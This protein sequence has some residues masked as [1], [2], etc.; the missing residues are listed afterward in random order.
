MTS[1]IS[2]T[3]HKRIPLSEPVMGGNEWKY[4][5]ECLDTG[6]VSSVGSFVDRFEE[7]VARYMGVSYAI[8]VVNGTS[9]LHLALLVAGVKEDDEVLV[10]TLTFIAP[11]NAVCYTGATPVFF[12]CDPRTF[13][14]DVKGIQKFF[15][16]ECEQRGNGYI[17]NKKTGRRIAA[18]I[19]VH[20]FGHPTDMDPLHAICAEYNVKLI[21]DATESMGSLYRG[22]KAGGLA[23]IGCLSFNGNKIITT[24]GGGMLVTNNK[25]W[26]DRA[27]HL[28]TQA[29]K[30][31]LLFDHNEIGYN[32]RLTNIH[33]AMGVAQME[34]LD[35][36]IARRRAIAN[37]YRERLG[38][39]PQVR[40]LQEAPA[41]ESNYW[42]STICV[43]QEH[44][45]PLLRHL[46]E[47]KI[48]ARPVWKLIHTLSMYQDC[49]S[50][51][52]KHAFVA[53]ATG[54]NIPS[55]VSLREED[56]AHVV[57]SIQ[58]YYG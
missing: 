54:I 9:A 34:V 28:S 3:S 48:Q 55:S 40:F 18:A 56:L 38:G 53:A 35:N 50:Y 36:Y 41:T 30:D 47:S 19:P 13:C 37:F 25:Q 51:N 27:R 15:L 8:A 57:H 45:H 42:L 26:A 12:D 6:W 31:P 24:G 43:A 44:Q 21:E 10:P 39:I 46:H 1:I 22:K 16:E 32:Y 58:N 20:I 4:I 11:V 52:I 7:T 17:Y 33:A 2:D 14:L 29:K 5:K 23:D 49:Q